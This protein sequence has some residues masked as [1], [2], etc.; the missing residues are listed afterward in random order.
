MANGTIIYRYR[1]SLTMPPCKEGVEWIVIENPVAIS[2]AQL[3]QLSNIFPKGNNRPI[4]KHSIIKVTE[5]SKD[6]APQ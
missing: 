1:G 3:T 5:F 4:Q 6:V 2:D